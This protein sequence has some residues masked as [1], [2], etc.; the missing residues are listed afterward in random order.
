TAFSGN[1]WRMPHARARHLQDGF[2]RLIRHARIIGILG[3][4][5]VGKTTF[6][7]A[8][9]NEY[10]S[11]DDEEEF[12]RASRSPKAFVD[13]LSGR[14][15]GIYECQLVPGLF[16]ALKV[17]IGTSSVPGRFILTG[18][19]RFTSRRAIRESLTGRIS[20]LE[21]LPF[22]LTEIENEPNSTFL[23]KVLAA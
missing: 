18:S 23:P 21:L 11:L 4:R 13:S 9:A 2:D 5:Q 15:S 8:N 7:G 14:R 22:C 6:L 20:N 19:V 16:P 17:K 3:H 1:I 10:V 12:E